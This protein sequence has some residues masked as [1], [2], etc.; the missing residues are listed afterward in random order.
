MSYKDTINLPKTKFSMKGNLV[1]REP[2]FLKKWE[3]EG[4][5][6]QIR[7]AK[8][9][10][11]KFILHD[12][13]PY[14]TGD[15]HIGTGLNKI[16]KD[17][18]TRF[19][20]M[21]GYDTP[22]IPGWDCH[23]LPIEHR[24]LQELGTKAKG[25][26]KLEIR[27]KCKKYAEKFVKVQMNQFKALGVSGDWDSA[28]LTFTPQYEAGIIEVFGRLV[29]KGYVYRSLK[30]IHWCMR[31]ETA[32][33]EAELEYQDQTSPSIYVNFKLIEVPK[34]LFPGMGGEDIHMLIWTTTPWTLPA[35]LAIAVHPECQYTA[36]RYINPKTQKRQVSILAE[37]LVNSVMK[38]REIEGYE[39]LGCVKG[40][41]LEG[42]KYQHKIMKR[43]GSVV[44]ANYVT[45]TDGTGCVHTAPGHGQDDYQTGLKYNLPIVS[46]VDATGVFTQEAGDFVGLNI[47]D[48]NKSITEKL[49]E[50]GLLFHMDKIGHSYPHCWRCRKPVIFRAT[51]QWFVG[52]D[53]HD[54]R[55]NALDQIKNSN[56]IPSWGEVRL[57]NMI[58]D[59]PDWC[60]SRQRS[61]GVPIPAFYCTHCEETL[62]D[63][64]VVNHV[65]DMFLQH[66]ADSWFYKETN[67]FLPEGTKCQKCGS[68]NFEKENDIFDVWFESGSSHH[69]VLNK[70]DALS[71]P[72]D[73]YLEGSDQ[74]RG[75][76][77]LSL[78]LS[79]AA[80][81]TAPFKT[82]LTHGFVVDEH[83][84]KMSKSLGN[85]VSV[86]DA[87]KQ[88]GG[89]IVRLWTASMEYRNEMHASP[90]IILKTSDPYRRI[91]NTFRYI[92][93]N[94]SDFDPEN[95]SVEYAQMPEIDR[96][97]LHKT[98]ELIT[99]VTSAYES[100]QFHRV[101]HNI[102][103]FCVVEMSSFYFDIMKDRLYTFSKSSVERRA[104]Q[105]V[106]HK[107]N[108]VLVR[109]IA[110]ILV[111]TSEEV[112]MEINPGG[113]SVHLSEWPVAV[114]QH[115]DITLN[116]K[117]EKIIK[118]KTDVA[119]ELEKM[120]VARQ[121]GSSLEAAVD[122][123]SEDSGLLNL[124]KE[125]EHDFAMIFIV[126]EVNIS[127]SPLDS[128][129]NGEI[130]DTLSIKT[131]VSD[132]GK[133]DRCWNFRKE[134]GK[135]EKYPTLCN[136]CAEVI[137][138]V[139]VKK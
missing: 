34:N 11:D 2:E 67:E 122:L 76:F 135:I 37:D 126:S 117:W 47:Y 88:L 105:T 75:W 96:W 77:Q 87:L 125:Y 112:W 130:F 115:K 18:I 131:R 128:G 73:I 89:D 84:K 55:T 114:E 79:V 116:D 68:T 40:S 42:L 12:G 104:T 139:E 85:F 21:K 98:D 46:P 41:A 17:I 50:L 72:A 36:I 62:L 29:E 61:W 38:L 74:H 49:D 66:G 110:P 35:N 123:Y 59:R 15:L 60:I 52:I 82:V 27:K 57:S 16:L 63:V 78:L 44:L 129:N 26:E 106:L 51:E 124:L 127:N 81:G 91:R 100:F 69:S 90:E 136:R 53:H 102:L 31:C 103:N 99:S 45:L 137:A 86:G 95:D 101:Y 10:A 23:G 4:L 13:P 22:Y 71:F 48:A 32:L 107:I 54:L 9:G 56:W 118:I 97:A 25:M 80:W 111:Y 133:C 28:Y 5:Y 120:R 7:K 65:R 121:I 138:E 30:P 92:L 8:E 14:P 64:N 3:K 132:S 83:G 58:K 43:E 39:R 94:L 119:R 113:S 134:V 33:A 109:L 70:R 24:V 6:A 19:Y 1:Q 108:S 20:T 93:G